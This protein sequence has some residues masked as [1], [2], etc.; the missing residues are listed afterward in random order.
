LYLVH[1]LL[2]LSTQDLLEDLSAERVATQSGL[3]VSKSIWN[4]D[5]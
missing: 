5:N 2:A 3:G 4:F 1:L